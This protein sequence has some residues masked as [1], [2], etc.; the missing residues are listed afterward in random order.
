MITEEKEA[1]Q[2]VQVFYKDQK[3]AAVR[4]SATFARLP[5]GP[6]NIL[7]LITVEA[8]GQEENG[9]FIP[10]LT[11]APTQPGKPVSVRFTN[12]GPSPAVPSVPKPFFDVSATTTVHQFQQT[13]VVEDAVGSH[14]VPVN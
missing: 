10:F 6:A 2:A 9:K 7:L 14:V 8:K 3:P 4:Y 12:L 11:F 1:A 5:V 13:I